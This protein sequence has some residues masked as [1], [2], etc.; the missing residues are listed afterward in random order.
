MRCC[1]SFKWYSEKALRMLGGK[2]LNNLSVAWVSLWGSRLKAGL[3][4]HYLCFILLLLRTQSSLFHNPYICASG[5]SS[6]YRP[7]VVCIEV[8]RFNRSQTFFR[9][10]NTRYDFNIQLAL[11]QCK[12]LCQKLFKMLKQ[13]P[14]TFLLINSSA[15]TYFFLEWK[16]KSKSNT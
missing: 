6:Q 16:S 12:L 15:E 3:D 4:L 9:C 13:M 5:G 7:W 11:N 10:K 1:W 14:T 2:S 8:D